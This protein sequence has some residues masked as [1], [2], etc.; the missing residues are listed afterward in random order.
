MK[1]IVKSLVTAGAACG[2]AFGAF[3]GA[4]AKIGEAAPDFALPSIMGQEVSLSNF[5]GK[6]VVLE[7]VNHGCPFVGKHYD[8]GNMQSLQTKY[9]AEGVVWLSICSSAQGAQG[10][11]TNEEWQKVAAK[12][13]MAST[14]VLVDASGKVGR[15]YEAKSTP[16]MFVINAQGTLV[17][18]G[19]IDSVA[20]TN[21][22]DIARAD[23][24]VAAALDTIMAGK[25]VEKAVTKPYGCSV[26]YK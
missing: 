3:A 6:V 5:H 16:H 23:N 24:Y 1:T 21:P 17:Y 10:Y 11:Y 26:K 18:D 8:S 9:M 22:A 12:K 2:L 19:A 4:K 15:M 14:A 20:S 25:L 13:G 7:W